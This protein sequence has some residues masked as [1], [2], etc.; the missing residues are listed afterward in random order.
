MTKKS[1]KNL[2]DTIE[3]FIG[4]NAVFEGTI[5]TDKVIRIDGKITGNIYSASILL[6]ANGEIIGDITTEVAVIGG[7]VKGNINASETTEILSK[8]KV[9]GNIRTNILTIVKG[10][11]FDGQSS[12]TT[13]EINNGA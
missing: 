7:L 1:S 4:Q 6:G 13:K 2:L 9:V 5:K 12:M 10:A 11:Y 3:V 8:A